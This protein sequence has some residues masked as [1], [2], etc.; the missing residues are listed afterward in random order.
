[1]AA[2]TDGKYG[3]LGVNQDLFL[4]FAREE[5]DRYS[6]EY[7]SGGTRDLAY[8]ALRLAYIDLLYKDEKPPLCFDASFAHQDNFRATCTMRALR[9]L[10]ED[11]VQSMIFTCRSRESTIARE[12]ETNPYMD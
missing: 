8:I 12:V 1:M 9:E 10:A 3:Q 4:D 6:A 2:M 11:G 7:L 5:G